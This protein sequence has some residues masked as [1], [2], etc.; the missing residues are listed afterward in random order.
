M[1][2][3]DSHWHYL[4]MTAPNQSPDST[5]C[6]DVKRNALPK[7]TLTSSET[8]VSHVFWFHKIISR[9]FLSMKTTTPFNPTV[10]FVRSVS[11][12]ELKLNY[13]DLFASKR[14]NLVL[15]QHNIFPTVPIWF[16]PAEITSML[17]I[18]QLPNVFQKVFFSMEGATIY[19]TVI[20]A[21]S[22]DR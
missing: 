12:I 22:T 20:T 3:R 7:S 11:N 2:I 17:K 19:A 15:L 13:Q 8:R 16:C 5:V 9:T 14:F 21:C 6:Q 4:S 18:I 10:V 1:C